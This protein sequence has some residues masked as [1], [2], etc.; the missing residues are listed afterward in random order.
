MS[1]LLLFTGLESVKTKYHHQLYAD[2]EPFIEYEYE[3]KIYINANIETEVILFNK[4]NK[5][6]KVEKIKKE[7]MLL[8]L[9][10]DLWLSE[11]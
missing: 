3:S 7:Y 2:V 8:L 1:L 4:E 10:E 9:D 6:I 11:E 5:K